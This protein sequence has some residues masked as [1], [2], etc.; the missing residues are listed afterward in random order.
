MDNTVKISVV[1]DEPLFLEGLSLLISKQENIEI[2]VTANSGRE[3]LNSL[4]NA[5]SETFPSIALIDVQ[6]KP[7]NGFELVEILK[8]KYPDLKI[9]VLSSHYKKNV[10]GHMV[11]LGISAFIPKNANK[12]LFVEIIESVSKYGVY[13][14]QKDQQMLL[15]YMNDKSKKPALTAVE[16]LSKREIEVLKLI[17]KEQTNQKIAD[18]LFISKR[19]VENHRQRLLEK[20]RAKNTVGLVVYAIVNEIHPIPHQLY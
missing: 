18:S 12:S 7:M 2:T 3:L 17:C 5:P 1:D 6:M 16:E 4:S 19:T 10:L 11:K 20:V 15:S 14:T 9:V 13:F 8:E